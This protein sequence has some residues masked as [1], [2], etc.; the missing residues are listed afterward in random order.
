[1]IARDA[2]P[3]KTPGRP[4]DLYCLYALDFS[5]T[6]KFFKKILRRFDSFAHS[7]LVHA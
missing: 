4:Q 3:Y 1:M 2:L 6:A 5:V 7:E